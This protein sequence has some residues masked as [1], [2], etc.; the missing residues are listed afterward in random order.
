M[1]VAV[2]EPATG[3]GRPELCRPANPG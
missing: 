1:S 3:A 2:A